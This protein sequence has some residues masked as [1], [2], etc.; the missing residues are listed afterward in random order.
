M[1]LWSRQRTPSH[2]LDATAFV[3]LLWEHLAAMGYAPGDNV[4]RG[5]FVEAVFRTSR[6]FT[7][8]ALGEP[9]PSGIDGRDGGTTDGGRD[10]DPPR[11]ACRL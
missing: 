10:E 9:A 5:D 8:Q 11:E 3:K 4:L 6:R 7:S 1:R 2:S